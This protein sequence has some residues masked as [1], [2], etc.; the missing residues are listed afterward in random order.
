MKTKIIEATQ[1]SEFNWG[2]FLVGEFDVEWRRRS[3]LPGNDLPIPLLAQRGWAA[4]HI[5]AL[6]LETGEGIILS[7][8]EQMPSYQLEHKHEIWRCPMFDPFLEWLVRQEFKTVEDLP[9]YVMLDTA[10][11]AMAGG[12][13]RRREAMLAELWEGVDSIIE[14]AVQYGVNDQVARAIAHVD[15]VLRRKHDARSAP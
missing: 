7:K 14:A 5:L 8:H 9:S 12:R 6:D 1:G 13:G 10:I 4:H 15:R 3:E 11:E 2:K